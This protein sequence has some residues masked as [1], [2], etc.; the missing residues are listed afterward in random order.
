PGTAKSQLLSCVSRISPR[1]VFCT[2]K[3]SSA[4]GLTA[5][6][7]KD[8]FGEGNWTLEAG[9]LVL[10]DMGIA[11]IDEI[12]KMNDADREALHPAMEQQEVHVAKAG[13]NATLRAR[14]SIL[15]AANPKLGRFDEFIPTHEQIKMPITLLS[16]FDLIFPIYDKPAKK[17]DELLASHILN[18]HQNPDNKDINPALPP[19]FVLKY[20][21]YAKQN[22][23]PKITD[24][25]HKKIKNFYVDLRATS[26]ES[27]AIT[28][29][30]LEAIIRLSEASAKVR[31]STEVTED[32]AERAI[33][34]YKS[35]IGR[36]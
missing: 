19:D 36:S 25:V 17:T 14:C 21:T 10:A 16:R 13:I 3:G 6:A 15:A 29:R 9:A 20:V 23:R 1:S 32:D 2:G 18:L 7:V 30:Q 34:I 35:Y 22:I 31:L 28:P 5:A 4:A 24:K 12:D 27:V 8:D 33:S 26:N 11:C